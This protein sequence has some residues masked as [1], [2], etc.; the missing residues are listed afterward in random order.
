[1]RPGSRG[2]RRLMPNT[3]MESDATAI[4]GRSRDRTYGEKESTGEMTHASP[5]TASV[6]KKLEPTMLPRT[7]SFSPRRAD[8]TALA[9]SGSDVP[10]AT[11]VRPITRSE[12]PIAFARSTLPQTRKYDDATSTTSPT[13]VFTSARPTLGL[14]AAAPPSCFA[15]ASFPFSFP[16]PFWSSQQ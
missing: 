12:M 13:T 9:S 2:L 6:L 16:R 3:A 11:I 15:S 7:N 5:T 14:S 1:M 4:S 8:A 10:T